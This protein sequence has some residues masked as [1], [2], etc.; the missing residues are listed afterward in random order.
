MAFGG[1]QVVANL[2]EAF[3]F[4][5]QQ[6][7][8]EF[9]RDR[10]VAPDKAPDDG[11]SVKATEQM[12]PHAG[13]GQLRL[14]DV[15]RHLFV[16]KEVKVKPFPFCG[17]VFDEQEALE[18][19]DELRKVHWVMLEKFSQGGRCFVSFVERERFLFCVI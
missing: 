2:I 13:E 9:H 6:F 1:I 3:G 5:T 10:P 18:G 11:V 14:A 15:E 7:D 12:L 19:E 8:G 4:G 17:A 16:A